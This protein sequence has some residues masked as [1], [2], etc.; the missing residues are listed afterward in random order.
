MGTTHGKG[1]IVKVGA[2]AVLEVVSFEL[3]E[4]AATADDSSMGDAADTHQVGRVGWTSKIA[5][6]WDPDDSTGQE[7]MTI[8]AS[9]ALGQ[10]PEG[11]TSGDRQGAGTGSVVGVGVTVEK[12]G[13]NQREFDILGNG[14]WAWSNVA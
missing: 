14:P 3:S 13:I 8:G 12:D 1:G 5:V 7:A 9:V 10:F 6:H 11:D 4:V 2:N